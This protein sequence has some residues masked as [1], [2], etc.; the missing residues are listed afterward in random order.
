V[1]TAYFDTSAF[2]KLFV[3][4]SG[5]TT[6]FRAWQQ[7]SAVVGGR[8]LYVEARASLA[9]AL[10]GARLTLQTYAEAKKSLEELW[11]RVDVVEVSPVVTQL[12]GDLAEQ[13]T[14][15]GY[16]AVHLASALRTQADVL[17]CADHDL[18][19]AAR[20]RGLAVIDAQS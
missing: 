2:M 4:E 15:R 6:A 13:H 19:Y 14:L 16:D 3:A 17:V 5:S 9:A 10:R 7:V 12:A 18:L 1:S 8:L 20:H 11:K